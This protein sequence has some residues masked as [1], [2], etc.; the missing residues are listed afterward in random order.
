MAGLKKNRHGPVHLQRI[1][2]NFQQHK[3]LEDLQKSV[4]PGRNDDRCERLFILNAR[5][6]PMKTARELQIEGDQVNQLQCQLLRT[7][8]GNTYCLNELQ[9]ESHF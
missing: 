2:K 5:C 4:R 6:H 7:F 3:I 8:S 1:L 9:P